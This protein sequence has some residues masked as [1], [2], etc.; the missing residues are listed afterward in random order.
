VAKVLEGEAGQ[1]E[2]L[3][4]QSKIDLAEQKPAEAAN[5]LRR[6]LDQRPD[7]AQAHFL[8]GSALMLSKDLQGARASLSRALE[9]DAA[10]VEASRLLARVHSQLGDDE[11][12]SRWAASAPARRGRQL[13]VLMAQSLARQRKFEDAATQLEAIPADQRDARRGTRRGARERH[14]ASLAA[15]GCRA[16]QAADPARRVL[17][18]LDLDVKDGCLPSRRGVAVGPRPANDAR[19]VQLGEAALYSGDRD[20]SASFQRDRLSTRTPLGLR[21]S[22]AT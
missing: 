1:P 8:L 16:A 7:W 18:A 10:L 5:A 15:R 12:P 13:R 9:L 14:A 17:R 3:F 2:A 4:V 19:L 6:A 21:S 20:G 11:L 22:R